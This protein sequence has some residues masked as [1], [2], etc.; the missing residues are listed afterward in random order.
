M[1]PLQEPEPEPESEPEAED[2]SKPASALSV[3][4]EEGFVLEHL[5]GMFNSVYQSLNDLTVEDE[6]PRDETPRDETPRDETPRAKRK[7]TSTPETP[8]KRRQ[9]NQRVPRFTEDELAKLA[10]RKA[11]NL[12]Q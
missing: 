3:L 9:T 8:T 10:K 12:A 4:T 7:R 5:Q 2:I 11:R 6:T 1:P